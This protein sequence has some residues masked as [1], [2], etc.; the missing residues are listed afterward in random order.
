[1]VLSGAI[2]RARELASAVGSHPNRSL[3]H[4]E[5]VSSAPKRKLKNG[6]LR[7]PL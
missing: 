1:M 4:L 7:Q 6:G 2:R 3:A 5:P